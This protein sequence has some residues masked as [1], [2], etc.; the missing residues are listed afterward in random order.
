MSTGLLRLKWR[1]QGLVVGLLLLVI[2][3]VTAAED[4][5]GAADLERVAR[6]PNSWIVDYS[7]ERIPEYRLATGSMKKINGVISPE[8][9]QYL[10]GT[11]T[12]ITYQLPSGHSSTDAF[13]HFR[14][15][16]DGLAPELL[17]R[18]EAR[19]CGDSNQWANVQFGIARL[20]GIDREQYYQALKLPA[21]GAAPSSYL[22]FYTVMRGNKRV[23]V[24]L[25]LLQPRQASDISDPA[26][27]IAELEQ[28]RR[29]YRQSGS[30]TADEAEMLQ[31]RMLDQPRLQLALVG[32]SDQGNSMES[33]TAAS[34]KAAE[35]LKQTLLEQGLEASRISAYGVG[36]LAPAYDAAVPN[37]RVE[38]LLYSR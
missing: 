7:Q 31:Q 34:L 13:N 11:L 22:A 35:V 36:S 19:G 21:S 33:T 29:V 1:R 37:Q 30:L 32:H 14:R 28:G 23:Y 26:S 9:E 4:L 6:Y 10:A 20:Y 12:R 15:Q 8:Q 25:D 17:F 5:P 2:Q 16:F 27:F 24:Q 18:C 38:L 3:G